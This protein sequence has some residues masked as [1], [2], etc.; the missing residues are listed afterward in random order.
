MATKPNWVIHIP[1]PVWTLAMLVIAYLV[2]RNY[3]PPVLLRS[4]VAGFL[5]GL[6]G[7]ALAISAG[8]LFSVVDTEI[9]P[10]SES[11]R[12]LV[13][14]GPFR[15]TRNPMYLG[16]LLLALGIALYFGTLPFLVV[17]PLAFLLINFVFI[18]F[19]EAKM[20]RQFGA[21]YTDYRASVRRWL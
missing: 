9:H 19:E 2:H 21:Q 8:R 7:L 5:L 16:L 3:A 20:Q 18:P 13:T 17:V 15:F 10:A 1:P 6:A 14:S 11:N 4:P 12:V